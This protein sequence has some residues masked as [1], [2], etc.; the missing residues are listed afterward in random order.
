VPHEMTQGLRDA[1]L[2]IDRDVT[3]GLSEKADRINEVFQAHGS[4]LRCS[5]VAGKNP[6]LRLSIQKN[7]PLG[8]RSGAP[9][10]E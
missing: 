10:V 7:T 4:N 6:H 2:S 1:L 5:V 8:A 3:L 9:L